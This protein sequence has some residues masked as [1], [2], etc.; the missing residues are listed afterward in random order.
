MI[1]IMVALCVVACLG[2]NWHILVV[3]ACILAAF[4][5]VALALLWAN[6]FAL[7]NLHRV[8]LFYSGGLFVGGLLSFV[9]T[10][11]DMTRACLVLCALPLV[12]MCCYARARVVVLGEVVRV[13]SQNTHVRIPWKAALLIGAY[14][15]AYGITMARVPRD[16]AEMSLIACI[17]AAIVF[18]SVLLN[19]KRFNFERVHDVAFPLMLMG[20]LAVSAIPGIEG[21][22]SAALVAMSYSCADMLVLFIV[23]GVAFRSGASPFW[24]FGVMKCIQYCAKFTGMAT[25]DILLTS[26]FASGLAVPSFLV[27]LVLVG[28]A[29]MIFLTEKGTLSDWGSLPSAAAEHGNDLTKR[30]EPR[31]ADRIVSMS[32]MYALTQRESEVL[33]L[34]AQGKTVKGIGSDMFIAEGTVKAHIQHIYQKMDVHS[35][36]ELMRTL[37]IE[38]P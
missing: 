22:V 25:C 2:L 17:P 36:A 30:N 1:Q 24:L 34:L 10:G 3:P 14:A 37:G 15:L 9:F 6:V 31:V 35:R 8:A 4:G 38:R 12:G 21:R 33:I 23:C 11:I 28:I 5:T 20:F 32:D 29:S 13:C 27:V 16:G 18:L 7:L 19:A 26:D